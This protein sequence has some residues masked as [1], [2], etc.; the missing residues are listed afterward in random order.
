MTSE[1]RAEIEA[2]IGKLT[3]ELGRAREPVVREALEAK[4]ADLSAELPVALEAAHVEDAP[5]ELAPVER[6]AF[7]LEIQRVRLMLGRGEREPAEAG[8]KALAGTYGD[9]PELLELR[10]DLA[11]GRKRVKEAEGLYARARAL[12]PGNVGIEKKHA[13][14]VFAAS[15]MGTLEDQLRA[16]EAG[17]PILDVD[18]AA[19]G[20]VATLM[21]LFLPGL[22]QIVMGKQVKGVAF[23][24]VWFVAAL[25]VFLH[26]RMLAGL[27]RSLGFGSGG[28]DPTGLFWLALV[29]MV[30]T[31]L[32]ALFDCAA[33]AKGAPKGTISADRPKPPV[34][35]PFE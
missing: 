26:G 6:R 5:R 23:L 21:T 12:A 2:L 11:L 4:I 10:G 30:G 17:T 33:M 15:G 14:A 29:V 20:G 13:D 24:T 9:Q 18:R 1:R 19:R 3:V 32:V 22:G 31:A 7:D 34:D 27:L 16:S 25:Y 35:L 8:V 28:D